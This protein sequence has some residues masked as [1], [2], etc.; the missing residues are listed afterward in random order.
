MNLQHV[1]V[2]FF[3]DGELTV[4]LQDVIN[5]F[6]GWVAEQS[7]DEM[8]IDV[9]D[10]RHVPNGPSVVLVGLKADYALDETGGRPGL[11]YSRKSELDASGE[12]QVQAAIKAAADACARLEAA[13][14]GL[15]FS[16]QEFEVT[17]NDRAI[18]PNT[19]ENATEL[20]TVIG[21]ALT[22]AFGISDFEADTTRD[23]RQLLGANVK[24]SSAIEF[25]ARS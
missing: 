5:T 14:E 22:N 11:L 16:R 23:S 19:A 4:D 2:K 13:F 3:V 12:D 7:M 9:A 21:A 20:T 6:H 8:M 17:I 15:T 24:L 10:Y 18:A 1:R 25:A